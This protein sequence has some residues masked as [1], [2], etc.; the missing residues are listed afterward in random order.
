[1]DT[2]WA[3]NLSLENLPRPV[4]LDWFTGDDCGVDLGFAPRGIYTNTTLAWVS[5][6]RKSTIMWTIPISGSSR[7]VSGES[8]LQP[9][10]LSN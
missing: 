3:F 6:L 5:G 2:G 9:R 1:M 7:P 10:K 4:A 8:A